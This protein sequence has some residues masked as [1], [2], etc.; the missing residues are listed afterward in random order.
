MNAAWFYG[1]AFLSSLLLFFYFAIDQVEMIDIDI[2]GYLVT[3]KGFTI[4]Q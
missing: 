2:D 1:G 4:R 3:F